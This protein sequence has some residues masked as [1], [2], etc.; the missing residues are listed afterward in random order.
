MAWR[1]TLSRNT[2]QDKQKVA[3]YKIN[4]MSGQSRHAAVPKNQFGHCWASNHLRKEEN[5]NI[6]QTLV[7]GQARSFTRIEIFNQG[8]IPMVEMYVELK[9]SSAKRIIRQVLP[10]P[11]SPMSNS[12]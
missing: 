4:D 11:L 7:R 12:L 10:T 1:E 9:L 6:Q 5:V 3:E 2:R 8:D